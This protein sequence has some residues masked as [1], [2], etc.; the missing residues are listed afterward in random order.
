MEINWPGGLLDIW[1]TED[2]SLLIIKC[3]RDLTKAEKEDMGSLHPL[4]RL[5]DLLKGKSAILTC[6]HR[7]LEVTRG[8]WFRTKVTMRAIKS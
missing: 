6:H 1:P 4:K 3:H 7:Q 8:F 2:F 5:V